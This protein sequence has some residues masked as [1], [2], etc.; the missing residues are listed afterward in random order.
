MR[1]REEIEKLIEKN[2][3]RGDAATIHR[4]EVEG[5]GASL[6]MTHDE[7]C[8]EFLG[9]YSNLW[10]LRTGGMSG[11]MIRSDEDPKVPPRN[12]STFNDVVLVF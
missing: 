5:I 9:L 1:F 6:N 10:A 2:A 12:W 7:A 11:G 3:R 4:R 8:R